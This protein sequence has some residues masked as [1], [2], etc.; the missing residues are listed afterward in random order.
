MS[1]LFCFCGP[2][3]NRFV[4]MT[5]YVMTIVW[6]LFVTFC[7]VKLIFSDCWI[8]SHVSVDIHGFATR[9][10]DSRCFSAESRALLIFEHDSKMFTISLSLADGVCRKFYNK[11]FR[12][13]KNMLLSEKKLLIS[14]LVWGFFLIRMNITIISK[15]SV[16][17]W[18]F[19]FCNIHYHYFHLQN[20]CLLLEW[21]YIQ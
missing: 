18:Y 12:L 4:K 9:F 5:V 19:Q 6:F 16:C 11:S 1:M 10:L 21:Y 20:V 13:V 3:F 2:F 17:F 14:C 8:R 15:W 7:V